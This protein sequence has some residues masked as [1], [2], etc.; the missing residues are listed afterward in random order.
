MTTNEGIECKKWPGPW[1]VRLPFRL[2][3]NTDIS[4][5]NEQTSTRIGRW[6]CILSKDECGHVC[7]FTVL[8][9]K[10]RAELFLDELRGALMWTQAKL[11]T[12]IRFDMYLDKVHYCDDPIKAA[13]RIFGPNTERIV[14][15][16]VSG[17]VPAIYPSNAKKSTVS[18]FPVGVGKGIQV[19]RFVEAM[20][21][22]ICLET[23]ALNVSNRRLKTASDLYADSHYESSQKSRFLTQM[24]VLEVLADRPK[25]PN[26][27]VALVDSW[28]R[29]I[30]A[31]KKQSQS[32][33]ETELLQRLASRI[34]GLKS[35]SI[36]ESVRQFMR[37]VMISLG[38][39][40]VLSKVQM[41]GNLY[42]VRS[43]LVHGEEIELGN[44]SAD[45]EMLVSRS[46]I[47]AQRNPR[48]L[49]TADFR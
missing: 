46:L 17:N 14:E 47:A 12:G 16:I 6:D 37:R 26:E 18:A 4:L 9:S 29:E 13:Q 25:Q 3:P 41:I 22:G 45:L 40:D 7:E 28:I 49:E 5:K 35:I 38:D 1:T 19:N 48:L 10:E 42:D 8:P 31:R 21:E 44:S 43:K 24:I 32:D 2:P 39:E 30:N 33:K 11:H 20:S 34:G 15:I 23:S 36:A 27:V